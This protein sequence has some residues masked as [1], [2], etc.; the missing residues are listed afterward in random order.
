MT[1][2]AK[3]E[4]KSQVKDR[5]SVLRSDKVMTSSGAMEGSKGTACAV[6]AMN[7]TDSVVSLFKVLKALK[8][9]T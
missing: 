9:M 2:E 8:E 6:E 4:G 1:I 5:Q 3:S 7:E